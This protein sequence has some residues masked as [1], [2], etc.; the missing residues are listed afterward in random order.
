ME[1]YSYTLSPALTF[2]EFTRLELNMIMPDSSP[3]ATFQTK[4]PTIKLINS[5]AT[6]LG[7]EENYDIEYYYLIPSG[8]FVILKKQLSSI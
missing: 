3:S 8:G 7:E 6:Q 4:D 2:P 1:R 5:I